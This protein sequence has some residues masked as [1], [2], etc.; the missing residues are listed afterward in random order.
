MLKG[1]SSAAELGAACRRARRNLGMRLEDA[2]LAA[3]VVWRAGRFTR[4]WTM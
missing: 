2:A 1:F 4:R 3:G